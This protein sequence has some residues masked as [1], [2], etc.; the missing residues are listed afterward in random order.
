MNN[1]DQCNIIMPLLLN[2]LTELREQIDTHFNHPSIEV[3]DSTSNKQNTA[4]TTKIDQYIYL[5]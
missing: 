2:I 1:T 5:F 3:V 4:W